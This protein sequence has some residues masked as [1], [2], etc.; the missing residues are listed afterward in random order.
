MSISTGTSVS[1]IRVM[2]ALEFASETSTSMA[3]EGLNDTSAPLKLRN[4][5][6]SSRKIV[7]LMRAKDQEP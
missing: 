2:H 7:Q 5:S 4:G 1:R 6:T 3:E